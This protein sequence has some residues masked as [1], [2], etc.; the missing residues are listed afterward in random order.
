MDEASSRELTAWEEV[1]AIARSTPRSLQCRIADITDT[2][3]CSS[4]EIIGELAP[5]LALVA[6]TGM[7]TQARRVWFNAAVRALDGIPILLLKRGVEAA[8]AKADHPSK[9][10][11]T[12]LATVKDDWNWRRNYRAPVPVQVWEPTR[13]VPEGERQEV[14]AMLDQLLSKFGSSE[15]K[16][17]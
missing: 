12:I 5:L 7:D 4:E 13:R 3:P 2:D 1:G 17:A 16:P 11:P 8:T 14:A 9:I 10:V 6:P 15:D